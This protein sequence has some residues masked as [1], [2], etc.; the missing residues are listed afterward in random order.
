[1]VSTTTLRPRSAARSASAADVVVLPTP[2]APQH[3][4]IWVVRS[5]SSASTSSTGGVV[6][7]RGPLGVVRGSAAEERNVVGWSSCHPLVAQQLGQLDERALVDPA[8]EARQL[9]GGHALGSDEL[10]LLVLEV[11][12]Y[13]S[14]V[15]SRTCASALGL[16]ACGRTRLTTT[17]PTGRPAARS[18]PM[19]SA[20]SWT[21]ISSRIV[22]R[23]TAVRGE[24]SSSITLS[25]WVLIGPTFASPASSELT[26]R[27]WQMR[28]VG[29]ASRT[30]ASY[31]IWSLC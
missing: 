4:M 28:P 25:A 17:P 19:P 30:T 31:V 16:R 24:R 7:I 23:C 5:S 18:S 10:T 29:G 6:F 12:A 21:G 15:S 11:T 1:M 13:G 3:T 14:T 2:P 9:V 27:N 8:R 22:T 20:V 26:P